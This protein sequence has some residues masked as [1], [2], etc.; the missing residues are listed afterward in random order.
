MLDMSNFVMGPGWNLEVLEM[1]NFVMGTGY[2]SVLDMS[3][4]VQINR[5]FEQTQRLFLLFSN[6]KLEPHVF[7]VIF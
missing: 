7:S 4:F 3:N 2:R 5:Y 1:S 6:T